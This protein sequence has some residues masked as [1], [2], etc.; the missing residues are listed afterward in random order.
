MNHSSDKDLDMNKT[1]DYHINEDRQ[2]DES[3]YITYKDIDKKR[4]K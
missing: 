3:L 4:I 1:D 2:L